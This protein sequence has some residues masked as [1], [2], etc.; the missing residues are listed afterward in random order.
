MLLTLGHSLTSCLRAHHC[1]PQR[2][3]C[4]YSAP[5]PLP[6]PVSSTAR[7]SLHRLVCSARWS[8]PATC[9]RKPLWRVAPSTK[10]G[11]QLLSIWRDMLELAPILA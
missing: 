10:W 5:S 2:R 1:H 3:G 7:L 6:N 11:S 8:W 9:S 4:R